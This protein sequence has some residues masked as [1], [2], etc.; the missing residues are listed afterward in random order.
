MKLCFWNN[1]A[2]GVARVT[3]S[4][5]R[6]RLV[7]P[8]GSVRTGAVAADPLL[9][10]YE[11]V[12]AGPRSAQPGN[13]IT[14]PVFSNDGWTVTAT[15]AE[16]ADPDFD[17]AGFKEKRKAELAAVRWQAEIAGITV[18]GVSVATDRESQ[19]KLIAARVMAKEDAAYTV[20]W[21]AESGFVDLDATTIIAVADAVRAHVQAMF[22][23]E[24][25]KS[26]EIDA[27]TTAADVAAYQITFGQGGVQ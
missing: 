13:K 20:K 3:G 2:P 21:K 27:L 15:Y 22:D 1:G 6:R 24:A 26:A 17:L 4:G 18:G 16:E 12:E 14:G 19:A 7:M 5:N 25:I 10:L 9:D 8:D 11:F 23:L